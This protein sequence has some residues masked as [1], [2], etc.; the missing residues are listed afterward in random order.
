ML[1]AASGT[2]AGETKRS[3]DNE[4][5][6]T[7][8]KSVCAEVSESKVVENKWAMSA[9]QEQR[10]VEWWNVQ[11]LALSRG[12]LQRLLAQKSETTAETMAEVAPC[13]QVMKKKSV[14]NS[15]TKDISQ[16]SG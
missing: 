14:T 5:F 7:E 16:G 9:H 3:N 4:Q 15:W 13:T 10:K 6:L 12:N 1:E 8:L 2:Q 11:Q